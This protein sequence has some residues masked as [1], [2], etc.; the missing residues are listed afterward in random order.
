MSFAYLG[1]L[2]FSLAGMA[3]LDWR[4]RL[5]WFAVPRRAAVVRA[6]IVH[7]GGVIVF[8]IW[9]LVCIAAGAFARGPS[10]YLSGIELAPE[11]TLEEVFFLIF[12]CWLTM[13]C[14]TAA[15]RL[16][17]RRADRGGRL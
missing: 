4:Y 11:F 14:Y 5:F 9:D 13:N 15:A 3:I 1:C 2:L 10:P 16:L 6:A 12:L 17:E 8:V 7:G